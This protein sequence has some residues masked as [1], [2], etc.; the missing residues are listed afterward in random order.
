M[1]RARQEL[2]EAGLIAYQDP[3]YQVL[4]LE[5]PAAGAPLRAE[6]PRGA[7]GLAEVLR[8]LKGGQ[9]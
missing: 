3:L 7:V 9:Q 8:S 6:R 1:V 2:L 5:R 4:S